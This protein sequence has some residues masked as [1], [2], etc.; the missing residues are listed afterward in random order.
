MKFTC[1]KENLLKGLQ[2]VIGI[3]T[4]PGNLPILSNIN[5]EAEESGVRLI[6]TN[7][8]IGITAYVRAKV[9]EP[10]SFTVPAKTMG[11][12][13]G[14][15]RQEHIDISLIKNQLLIASGT[16]STK[17]KGVSSEEFPVIPD[18]EEGDA[19]TIDAETFRQGMSDI[20][21]A[22]AK[23]EI[24]PELSGV[25]FGFFTESR[26][27]LT[28]AATDSYR[29]AEKTITV[30]QGDTSCVC[31]V[32]AKTIAEFIRLIG[33]HPPSGQKETQVRLWVSEN[34]VAIR[35]NECEITSR[36]IEGTYPDY[37]QIIPTKFTTV[38]TVPCDLLQ[39]GI[40]AASLFTNTG[41]NA[42][43]L[44]INPD[45]SKVNIS[46]L[47]AQTGEHTTEIEASVVGEASNILLNHKYVLD[48]LSHLGGDI[49]FQMNGPESPSVLRK[50]G[51]GDY[52]YIV[53]PIRQ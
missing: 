5:I 51:E 3:T 36:V 16:S 29:L 23:N 19:Y 47:S 34:Q 18:I 11:D 49:E 38:A 40:K 39:N 48:G 25:Y 22:A 26:P 7:L 1:T 17:I 10:G 46:S 20:V 6:S 52:G 21:F 37:T 33:L 12:F 45:S 42:V 9:S 27:G 2:L 31:I 41:V 14:L 53:M 50:S 4:K 13:V 8:E 15:I 24:R 35:Y 28:L 44:V 32:P 43:S 30:S